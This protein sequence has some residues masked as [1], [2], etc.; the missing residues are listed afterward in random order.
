MLNLDAMIV[1]ALCCCG[2]PFWLFLICRAAAANALTA[3]LEAFRR[4]HF[5]GIWPLL[6]VK[7]V[8]N[9]QPLAGVCVD[10]M[11][12]VSSAKKTWVELPVT[13]P[14]WCWKGDGLN[15]CSC[16]PCGAPRALFMTK[17]TVLIKVI[18]CTF[19]GLVSVT[20]PVMRERKF[21]RQKVCG[22]I[23]W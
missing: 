8:S 18:H 11:S 16:S 1:H 21:P 19:C 23:E 10:V 3:Y 6:H 15:L 9:S 7:R 17:E 5:C 22:W 12:K 20:R 2:P 13:E 14:V 4:F